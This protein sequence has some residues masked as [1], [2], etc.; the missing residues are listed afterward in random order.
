[1]FQNRSNLVELV[2][3]DKS[4]FLCKKKSYLQIFERFKPQLIK[5]I[6]LSPL[7]FRWQC[8]LLNSDSLRELGINVECGNQGSLSKIYVKSL[9]QLEKIRKFFFEIDDITID[10]L[11]WRIAHVSLKI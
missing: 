3:K 2:I 6:I 10:K 4:G 1:M 8:K 7:L 5:L 9:G 11:F